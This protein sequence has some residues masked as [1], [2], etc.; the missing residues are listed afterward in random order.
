M[1]SNPFVAAIYCATYLAP[2]RYTTLKFSNAQARWFSIS[3]FIYAI[4]TLIEKFLLQKVKNLT[5]YASHLRKLLIS[6]EFLFS[7]TAAT[8]ICQLF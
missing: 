7:L 3:R 4:H 2:A 8:L 6:T 1:Y 5:K